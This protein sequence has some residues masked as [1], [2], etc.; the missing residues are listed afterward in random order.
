MARFFSRL[1]PKGTTIGTCQS[2]LPSRKRDRLAE[3]APRRADHTLRLRVRVLQPIHIH[4]GAAN[5]E[6]AKLRVVLV[7]DP[8]LGAGPL[9]EQRPAIL[10]SRRHGPVDD[11]GGVFKASIEGSCRLS[12][13]S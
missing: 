7:L 10:R 5:L 12:P 6:G 1:L 4:E 2:C 8:D 13:L 3:V 9:L 11:P